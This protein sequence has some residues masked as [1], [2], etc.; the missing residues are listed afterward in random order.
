MFQVPVPLAPRK[1]LTIATVIGVLFL[2]V[3]LQLGYVN[4]SP[5]AAQILTLDYPSQVLT[6]ASFQ[7][8]VVADYSDRVGVD[9]GIWSADAGIILQ[10]ISIPL[11]DTGKVMFGF[12]LT[13]PLE[14]TEWRLLAV[15]RIWW[16]NAWYQ[17]PLE[18]SRLFTVNVTKNATLRMASSGPTLQIK[19]D[20]LT[21]QVTPEGTSVSVQP[22]IHSLYTE[23]VLASGAGERFVFVGWSDGVNSDSRFIVVGRSLNVTALYRKEYYLSVNSDLGLRA[24]QGWYPAGSNPSFAVAPTSN[25]QSRFGLVTRT[26]RFAGWSG[27]TNS[28]DALA[29]IAMNGPESVEAQWNYSATSIDTPLAIFF[30]LLL[31]SLILLFRG[32]KRI[33]VSTHSQVRRRL[34]AWSKLALVVVFLALI[35]VQFPSTRAQLPAQAGRT[36][37]KIGDASWY[38]WN[39]TFSDTCMIWLGG[40]TTNEQ[41]VGHYSYMV[42]PL[43]YESFGTIRFL[44]H[45]ASN[46]CLIA[47]QKGSYQY[48]SPDS[49]RTIFQEPYTMDSVIIADVHDWI[50]KQGYAH[51]FLLGYST[52]AQVAA[53]EV[54]IRAPEEWVSPDGLVLITPRLSEIVTRNA[55]RT[56]GSLLVLYGGSIETPAY[57]STGHDFFVNARNDG[58]YNSS[59]FHK[60]FHVIEKMGHEVWTVY[61]TG[62]YDTQAERLL[63]SFVNDAKALQLSRKEIEMISGIVDKVPASASHNLNLTS[64]I[65]PSQLFNTMTMRVRTVVSYNTIAPSTALVLAFDPQTEQI[66]DTQQFSAVAS[67][68]RMLFL[69]FVPAANSTKQSLAVLV[70]EQ[71]GTVWT[72]ASGPVFTSTEIRHTVHVALESNV[73]NTPFLF[74]GTSFRI[75]NSGTAHL[76]TEP[77]EHRIQVQ[78]VTS[79]SSGTRIVFVGWEDGSTDTVR[80]IDLVNDTTILATYRVQ[81]F[82]NVTSP[83]GTPRGSGWY[84]ENSTMQASVDPLLI[85]GTTGQTIFSQWETDSNSTETRV[86]ISVQSP[87][88]VRAKWVQIPSSELSRTNNNLLLL[89][90]FF[91]AVTILWNLL[92]IPRRASNHEPRY[93]AH[94]SLHD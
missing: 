50:L 90:A 49:N 35:L 73:P 36:I 10:S 84:D 11:R 58:L 26:Y 76:D 13:A 85:N 2:S 44:Q 47:L 27:N 15:T 72:L 28:S 51:T 54:A 5:P 1:G 37:V 55:Y 4:A 12:N 87:T 80:L 38:Y 63:M 89:G 59:Y 41:E 25:L 83:Y 29:S 22:G 64:V 23:Q 9:A 31:G 20:N 78:P 30:A 91:L 19:L 68:S 24:G 21:Y 56:R 74:D 61:E 16:L 79:I 82:V 33:L 77:G 92:P 42:N 65:A 8:T 48:L 39:N 32:I 53:M 40:G 93:E 18:G 7:V 81:Y 71:S 57:V 60:E 43:E 67:G 45:L 94:W 70:L 6:G 17:D 75:P 46:Y 69:T 62:V 88:L 52:G 3:A 34:Q 14:P 86:L 66:E